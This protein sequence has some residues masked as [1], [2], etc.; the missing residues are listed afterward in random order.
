SPV[1]AVGADVELE[2]LDLTERLAVLP[3]QI[4]ESLQ[5]IRCAEIEL[6]LVR[7]RRCTEARDCLPEGAEPF[8]DCVLSQVESA[9]RFLAIN[10]FHFPAALRNESHAWWR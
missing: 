5:W 10:V 4:T 8:V 7:Q 3:R 2:V 9:L 1:H 6:N